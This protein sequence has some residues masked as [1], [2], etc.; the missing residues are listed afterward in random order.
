MLKFGTISDIDPSRGVVRVNLDD[1]EIVTNW[2]PVSVPKTKGDE[3]GFPYDV[4]EH[5]WCIMD[6]HCENGVVGGSLY[7]SSNKP[8]LGNENLFYVKFKDGTVIKYD[9]QSHKL[10]ATI[11]SAVYELDGNGHKIAVGSETLKKIISDLID[12]INAITVT[13]PSG[14]STPPLLNAATFNA[15]KARLSNLLL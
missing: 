3:I 15:I 2:I 4:N 13:T 12:A 1:D 8:T 5:V 10:T 11:D 9:R 6:E 7:D 14:P